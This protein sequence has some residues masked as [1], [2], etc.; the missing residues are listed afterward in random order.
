[1]ASGEQTPALARQTRVRHRINDPHGQPHPRLVRDVRPEGSR[2]LVDLG[3]DH[4]CDLASNLGHLHENL[5]A[6][7]LLEGAKEHL[8]H[9]RRQHS[10]AGRLTN[11]TELEK[12]IAQLRGVDGP[13]RDRV[14]LVGVQSPIVTSRHRGRVRTDKEGDAAPSRRGNDPGGEHLRRL[15]ERLKESSE[16]RDGSITNDEALAAQQLNK[17]MLGVSKKPIGI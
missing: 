11:G 14:V 1:M 5:R 4:L 15:R 9:R 10:L 13:H 16:V 8:R 6:V 12:R 7:T 17:R 2:R 3:I